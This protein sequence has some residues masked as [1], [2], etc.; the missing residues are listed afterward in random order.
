[1]GDERGAG[2]QV[3]D[4]GERQEFATGARRDTQDEKPRFELIT[5]YALERIAWVY[6]RGAKKYG[7]SN[8]QRGMPY[9]RYLASAFRHIFAYMRGKRDEDHLAMACWNLMAIMHHEE[10]GPER[11]RSGNRLDDIRDLHH[12]PTPVLAEDE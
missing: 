12:A 5:P 4:S 1:M 7:V 3:H 10:V 8:W 6:T 2:F 9:S 11:D